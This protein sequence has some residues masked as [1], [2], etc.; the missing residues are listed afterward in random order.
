MSRGKLHTVDSKS[1]GGNYERAGAEH[2][3]PVISITDLGSITRQ[4][5]CDTVSNSC[6]VTKGFSFLLAWKG[7]G[8]DWR[9]TWA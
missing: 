1:H 4:L 8:M 6:L 5:G 9:D 7:A 2:F 3:S